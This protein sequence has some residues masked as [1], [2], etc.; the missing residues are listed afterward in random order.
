MVESLMHLY[1]FVNISGHCGEEGAVSGC[2]RLTLR[3][4]ASKTASLIC[5]RSEALRASQPSWGFLGLSEVG[6]PVLPRALAS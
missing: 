5:P 6:S 4:K 3:L 1:L 2:C